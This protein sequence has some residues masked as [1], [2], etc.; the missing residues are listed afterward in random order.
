MSAEPEGNG[1]VGVQAARPVGGGHAALAL[2]LDVAQPDRDGAG[3]DVDGGSLDPELARGEG[4]RRRALGGGGHRPELEASGF[5][6]G[7]GTRVRG[8][9]ADLTVDQ[10]RW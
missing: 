7:P 10:V 5:E 1:G 3:A 2:L 9:A 6:V 8:A 4:G